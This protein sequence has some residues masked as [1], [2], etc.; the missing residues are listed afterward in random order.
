MSQ[1]DKKASNLTLDSKRREMFKKQERRIKRF[2][3]EQV[4]LV[5]SRVYLPFSIQ[6]CSFSSVPNRQRCCICV[7]VINPVMHTFC[8]YVFIYLL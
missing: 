3:P 6:I 1:N 4:K 8:I 7:Y 2:G 5:R